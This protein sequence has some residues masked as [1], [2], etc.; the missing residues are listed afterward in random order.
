MSDE[1]PKTRQ[2]DPDII[3]EGTAITL[4]N[5]PKKMNIPDAIEA[6][7]RKQKDNETILDV[8]EVIS[9]HP[10]DALV[11][12]S[13]AMKEVYGWAS[14]TPSMTFF[15]PVAPDMITIRTGPK[16]N[17]FMQLPCGN[18]KLPNIDEPIKVHLDFGGMCLHV[19]GE[20]RKDHQQFLVDLANV[21]RK[22][23]KEHSIFQ[24]KALVLPSDS[25]GDPVFSK[26]EF[27]D[28]DSIRTEELVL[29][30]S[31]LDQVG[32]SLWTP[33]QNKD[34]CEQHSIPLK[35]T[36]LLEG[37]FGTGKTLTAHATSR[38]CVENE[39]TFILLSD[40][41]GLRTTL[42]FARR[43]EPCVVFAEDVD[44]IASE[45]DQEG[46]D[47]LNTID[48][49]LN[50]DS[51][52]ITVLTTNFA[53]RLD[54]AMLRPGR[55]DA[56]ISVRPPEPEA[57][58]QLLRTYGRGLIN[59]SDTLEGA[60][61]VLAGNIPATIR[62]CVERSKLGMIRRGG[63]TVTDDDLIVSAKGMEAHLALLNS[64]KDEVSPEHQLGTLMRDVVS[65]GMDPEMMRALAN[66][67]TRVARAAAQV[68][69]EVSEAAEQIT[70][71]T[72]AG[73][74]TIVK[75]LASVKRDTE[76]IKENVS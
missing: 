22:R 39:W 13:W 57:V 68:A 29:N 40:V 60:A 3:Y 34:V 59:P 24:G 26:L 63:D 27:F 8:H 46:N 51:R 72:K 30:P 56:V 25:D 61:A 70:E 31:E 48:G 47:L 32:T 18:F 62:E 1:T 35:R 52:V 37:P 76:I 53:D 64:E 66:S 6:L 54:R 5:L 19:T 36:V 17:D 7:A 2:P 42:E 21:A 69:G 14:P 43:Y 28:T 38:V 20:V 41:R 45:R 49:A 75:R 15:G 55:L 65:G 12:F 50:K 11:A 16:P 23:L 9:G 10:H 73:S 44:R 67:N 4:P 58:K 33:I 74:Q 71:A